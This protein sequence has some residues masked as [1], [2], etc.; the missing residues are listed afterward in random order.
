MDDALSKPVEIAALRRVLQRF[1][2]DEGAAK[3]DETPAP[4][5]PTAVK[6]HPLDVSALLALFDGDREFVDRL[7]AEFVAS[8]AATCDRLQ[9]AAAAGDRE[10]TRLA[11]H[12]LA[13]SARTVGAADLA[14][15]ADV[16]EVAAGANSGGDHVAM[17]AVCVS[18]LERIR[19]Q[20]TA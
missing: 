17:A 14:A 5:P 9:A 11:A 13:G 12:K 19:K 20:I 3:S 18:E 16:L 2:P 4:P 8:N 10:G 15:A 6:T 1:L 7:L